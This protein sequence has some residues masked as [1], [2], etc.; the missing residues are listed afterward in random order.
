V[1]VQAALVERPAVVRPKK[2]ERETEVLETP[3]ILTTAPQPHASITSGWIDS[4][5]WPGATIRLGSSSAE[6]IMSTEVLSHISLLSVL[7]DAERSLVAAS[8]RT[9]RFDPGEE[10]V[11]QGERG[12]TFYVVES[13]EL[14]VWTTPPQG[15][16]LTGVAQ[17]VRPILLGKLG[18]GTYFG[19]MSL[20]TGARRSATIKAV[21][22]SV[23]IELD[24]PVFM[25]LFQGNPGL[26]RRITDEVAARN[27]K[28]RLKVDPQAP[29]GPAVAESKGRG[30]ASQKDEA[31]RDDI[32]SRI[33]SVFGLS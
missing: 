21:S 10:V 1:A 23:V 4:G 17:V 16:T 30:E 19:E 18:P 3:R 15:A 5:P 14:E 31:A 11:R 32:F 9:R 33:K 28:R 27:A 12:T 13:G 8:G 29:Q 22:P 25:Q 2:G 6:K 20:L 7:S 26:V 24:R